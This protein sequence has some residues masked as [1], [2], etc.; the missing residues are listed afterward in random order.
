LK[1][2][3]IEEVEEAKEFGR[4]VLPGQ[5]ADDRVGETMLRRVF[6]SYGRTDYRSCQDIK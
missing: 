3:E 2:K 4:G 1:V 6:T 5:G